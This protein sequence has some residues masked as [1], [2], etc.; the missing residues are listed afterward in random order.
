[1]TGV[2]IVYV[3]A[4]LT[5]EPGVMADVRGE[6]AE[7]RWVSLGEAE[8]L[9]SGTIYEPVIRYLRHVLNVS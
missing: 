4:E 2:W 1:M 3:A 9:M 8:G 6:L 5:S 7:V